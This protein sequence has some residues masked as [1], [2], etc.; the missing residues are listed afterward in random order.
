MGKLE[1]QSSKLPRKC[2]F[3]IM[4]RYCYGGI[5]KFCRAGVGR[6]GTYLATDY[7]LLQART[8]NKVDFMSCVYGLRKQRVNSVQTSVSIIR[9][10]TQ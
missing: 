10:Y 5:I 3:E 8:E 7:L 9:G 6:S 1:S 4:N 2:V